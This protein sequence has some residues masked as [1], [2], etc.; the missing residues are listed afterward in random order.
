MDW[1][2]A[3]P[4]HVLRDA[5]CRRATDLGALPNG[6][7]DATTAV[8]VAITANAGNDVIVTSNSAFSVDGTALAAGWGA[9]FQLVGPGTSNLWNVYTSS[10]GCAGTATGEPRWPPV[11]PTPRPR[12]RPRAVPVG[13][14]PGQRGPA[15]VPAPGNITVRGTLQGT[16]NS[17]LTPAP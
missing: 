3:D 16:V 7:N 1:T 12:R 13:R 11:S 5:Q 15:A 2:T 17:N 14:L 4:D 6:W 8:T 10:G 9:R